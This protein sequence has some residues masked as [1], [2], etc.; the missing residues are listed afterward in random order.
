MALFLSQLCLSADSVNFGGWLF[1]SV[2][3]STTVS[4]DL[5]SDS[6]LKNGGC[7]LQICTLVISGWK[8]RFIHGSFFFLSWPQGSSVIIV[9]C[10]FSRVSVSTNSKYIWPFS[11]K[12]SAVITSCCVCSCASISAGQL[13]HS[14]FIR[15]CLSKTAARHCC[16]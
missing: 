2:L 16:W 7:N 4:T 11:F 12:S 8:S 5:Q 10:L 9:C 15:A 1:S 6:V 13:V 3:V 14:G